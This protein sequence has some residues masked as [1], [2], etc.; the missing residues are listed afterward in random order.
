MPSLMWSQFSVQE[1]ENIEHMVYWQVSCVDLS[2]KEENNI[3]RTNGKCHVS[4]VMANFLTF[5]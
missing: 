3:E 5:V 1:E 2:M 4:I